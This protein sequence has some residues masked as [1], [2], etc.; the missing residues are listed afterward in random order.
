MQTANGKI[1]LI[2]NTASFP[3]KGKP[4]SRSK[5]DF[6]SKLKAEGIKL[7]VTDFLLLKKQRP[8]VP[9]SPSSQKLLAKT[10]VSK[11]K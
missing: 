11:Q 5:L 10:N 2:I 9:L 4:L 8:K 3:T 7:Q 1:E 6:V